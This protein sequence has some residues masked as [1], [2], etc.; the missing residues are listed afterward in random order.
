M[1]DT[2]EEGRWFEWARDYIY[3]SK[4]LLTLRNH[5]P[6]LDWAARCGYAIV[7]RKEGIR[8][9]LADID[10]EREDFRAYYADR[11]LARSRQF[12]DTVLEEADATHLREEQDDGKRVFAD[13]L[14]GT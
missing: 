5:Y 10:F 11:H 6:Q 4:R 1:P 14:R 8:I 3:A 12:V 13:R 9:S 2:G 7:E